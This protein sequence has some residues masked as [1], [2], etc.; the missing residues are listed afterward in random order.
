M[1]ETYAAFE[2]LPLGAIKPREWLRDQLRI[3]ADGLT[4]HLDEH[5][6]DVGPDNGWLG[7][8]LG[9]RSIL[10]GRTAAASL[11]A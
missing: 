8:E 5:W 3:Q 7:G 6:A 10:C 2:A 1:T 11:P 4:G 9:T